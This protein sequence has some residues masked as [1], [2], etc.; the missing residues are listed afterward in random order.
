LF[1]KYNWCHVIDTVI[2][3]YMTVGLEIRLKSMSVRSSL[4]VDITSFASKSSCHSKGAPQKGKSELCV[5]M[6]IL[7]SMIDMLLPTF[8]NNFLPVFCWLCCI[9]VP[10]LCLLW[11]QGDW[12]KTSLES[13]NHSLVILITYPSLF[14]VVGRPLPGTSQNRTV[15]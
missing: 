7:L 12:M 8:I 15:R 3:L 13:V 2:Q 5:Y 1:H 11:R 6:H 14:H 9:L 4:E 10:S